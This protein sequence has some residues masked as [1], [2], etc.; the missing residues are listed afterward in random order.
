MAVGFIDKATG[1]I[2]ATGA[3]KAKS[4]DTSFSGGQ[5]GTLFDEYNLDPDM[6]FAAD[7][8]GNPLDPN[9]NPINNTADF[10]KKLDKLLGHIPGY[11]LGKDA[12]DLTKGVVD[13]IKNAIGLDSS[14]NMDLLNANTKAVLDAIGIKN[15]QDLESALKFSNDTSGL[16]PDLSAVNGGNDVG[17]T[18][19]GI[20]WVDRAASGLIYDPFGPDYSKGATDTAAT[21]VRGDKS[22]NIDSAA[23]RV[24]N[25]D[26]DPGLYTDGGAGRNND[27]TIVVEASKSPSPSPSPS[28]SIT[29]TP[30]YTGGVTSIEPTLGPDGE[31]VVKGTKS[32][33]PSPT[34]TL[35]LTFTMWS[36]PPPV[37]HTD[38]PT[39]TPTKSVTTT[40]PITFTP[41]PITF[42]PPYTGSVP[43]VEPTSGPDTLSPTASI[44]VLTWNPKLTQPLDNW[45]FPKEYTPLHQINLP[46]YQNVYDILFQ[47]QGAESPLGQS[48]LSTVPQTNM[49][50]AA[51]AAIA[52]QQISQQAVEASAPAVQSSTGKAHGGSVN[53]VID[54]IIAYLHHIRR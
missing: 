36:P 7:S 46:N 12:I 25:T 24:Y 48:M 20:P 10:G 17:Y 50:D 35:S 1:E 42:T 30:P 2:V 3:K 37:V 28:F 43:P 23:D 21:V 13:D 33:S 40:P 34:Q 5:Y 19:S 45:Q 47:G 52:P 39:P 9:G 32:P 11:S 29:L 51:L 22:S 4:S 49:V 54:G 18:S 8:S 31:I 27:P 44:P 38:T 41:P 14:I 6:Y 16:F 15:S 53:N 26:T